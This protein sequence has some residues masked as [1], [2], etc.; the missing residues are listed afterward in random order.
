MSSNGPHVPP[1][2]TSS[3]RRSTQTSVQCT[4]PI[5][6][7][8]LGKMN[9]EGNESIMNLRDVSQYH[10]NAL[11]HGSSFSSSDM[12]GY[13]LQLQALGSSV[14]SVDTLEDLFDWVN[15]QTWTDQDHGSLGDD[16]VSPGWQMQAVNV[17]EF[18]HQGADDELKNDTITSGC[19][20]SEEV[21]DGGPS[22]SPCHTSSGLPQIVARYETRSNDASEP[23]TSHPLDQPWSQRHETAPQNRHPESA[24]QS[25]NPGAKMRLPRSTRSKARPREDKRRHSCTEAPCTEDFSRTADLRRHVS[26]V[27]QKSD[28][29]YQCAEDRC[30]RRTRRQDKIRDHCRKVHRRDK[31]GEKFTVHFKDAPDG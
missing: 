3:Q 17:R 13:D 7:Y 21:T 4:C 30:P 31:G 16:V 15:D 11:D 25:T 5:H 18:A 9:R 2:S 22:L 1:S 10:H 8:V 28:R 19:L 27:H 20:I 14:N 6:G 29:H 24:T 26:D 23:T 12:S